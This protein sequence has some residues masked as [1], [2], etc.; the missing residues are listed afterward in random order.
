MEEIKIIHDKIVNEEENIFKL[1]GQLK[2]IEAELNIAIEEAKNKVRKELNKY[3]EKV[4]TYND[5]I[6]KK[7]QGTTYEFDNSPEWVQLSERRKKI[8]ERMKIASKN[9][10]QII[11]EETGEI[12][13]PATKK[14]TEYFTFK[15]KK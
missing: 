1:F 13:F 8:E 5:F 14:I 10:I 6:F 7:K 11:D 4:V 2:T 12:I 15:T 9:G 3:P